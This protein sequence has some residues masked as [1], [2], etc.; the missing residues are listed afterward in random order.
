MGPWVS[1]TQKVNPKVALKQFKR[2]PVS[3]QRQHI[4]LQ[5]TCSGSD[6]AG[7]QFFNVIWKL[8]MHGKKG[9]VSLEQTIMDLKWATHTGRNPP[10]GKPALPGGFARSG[11]TE[12]P[13][14]VS[15]S[16]TTCFKWQMF[17]LAHVA[18][19]SSPLFQ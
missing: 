13:R 2:T 8:D 12:C 14:G 3:T 6:N 5:D 19:I 4:S 18:S 1:N 16:S 7:S 15:G 11:Y 9:C 17:H 10:S